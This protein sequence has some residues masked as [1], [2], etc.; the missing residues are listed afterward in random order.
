VDTDA[1]LLRRFPEHALPL[2]DSSDARLCRP[3][4]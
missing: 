3:Y 1:E 4:R 2:D